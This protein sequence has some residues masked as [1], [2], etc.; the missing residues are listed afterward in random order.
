MTTCVANKPK[1]PKSVARVVATYCTTLLRTYLP[2]NASQVVAEVVV[3]TMLS[4]ENSDAYLS[5][6]RR[7]KAVENRNATNKD[8]VSGGSQSML[9]AAV[10][11]EEADKEEAACV[12][13]RS[14][15]CSLSN[16]HLKKQNSSSVELHI[17]KNRLL[18]S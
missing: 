16:R 8:A 10:K 18:F 2:I 5:I 7:K 4:L 1:L 17:H 13:K 6:E 15:R 3:G 14:W 12:N 9:L 11:Q